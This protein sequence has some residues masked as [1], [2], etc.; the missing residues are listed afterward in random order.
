MEPTCPGLGPKWQP[1]QVGGP[2]RS[3][4][5]RGGAGMCMAHHRSQRRS[6]FC[7]QL[8]FLELE[9]PKGPFFCLDGEE[10]VFVAGPGGLPSRG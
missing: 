9:G 7:H 5:E 4:Q 3:A 8:G 2:P 1:L 10:G 6:S